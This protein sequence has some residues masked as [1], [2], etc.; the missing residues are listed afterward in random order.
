MTGLII[1]G[2]I[3]AGLIIAG[4]I[5]AGLAMVGLTMAD[6]TMADLRIA[7]LRM[8]VNNRIMRM[9]KTLFTMEVFVFLTLFAGHKTHILALYISFVSYRVLDFFAFS[10]PSQSLSA[11]SISQIEVYETS[12]S[13]ALSISDLLQLTF[14]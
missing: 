7:D 10:P 3:T 11:E 13:L 4:S 1:A 6:L 8:A 9:D 2:S 5:I 12:S 14:A